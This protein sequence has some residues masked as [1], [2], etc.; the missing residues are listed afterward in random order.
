MDGAGDGG[1]AAALRHG[2]VD[3]LRH[4]QPDGLFRVFRHGRGVDVGGTRIEK[5]TDTCGIA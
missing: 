1:S 3:L 5:G 4:R 2:D